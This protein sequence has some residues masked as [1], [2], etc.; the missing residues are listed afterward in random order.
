MSKSGAARARSPVIRARSQTTTI[1]PLRPEPPCVAWIEL[2]GDRQQHS[3]LGHDLPPAGVVRQIKAP[4]G[5]ARDHDEHAKSILGRRISVHLARRG[6][7]S[8]RR[9]QEVATLREAGFVPRR[10]GSAA[11]GAIS[12]CTRAPRRTRSS[13]TPRRP[14]DAEGGRRFGVEAIEKVDE[15]LVR[16]RDELDEHARAEPLRRRHPLAVEPLDERDHVLERAHLRRLQELAVAVESTSD[17]ASRRAGAR[18]GLLR[19]AKDAPWA[20]TNRPGAASGKA[21]RAPR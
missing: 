18:R 3:E 4:A 11:G 12:R 19:R 15:L 8:K 7:S 21:R 16:A 17:G 9:Q 20:S 6:R 14:G 5:L 1:D 10:R 13:S 2:D